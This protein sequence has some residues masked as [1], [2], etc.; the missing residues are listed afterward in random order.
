[1]PRQA[2][3][4]A[5]LV[6]ARRGYRELRGGP[7]VWLDTLGRRPSQGPAGGWSG[8]FELEAFPDAI[9]DLT[10]WVDRD[11]SPA[12]YA[13]SSQTR[14]CN[15]LEGDVRWQYRLDFH[16]LAEDLYVPHY[17]DH[18]AREEE[19]HDPRPRGVYLGLAEA[20]EQLERHLV[21]RIGPCSGPQ[22]GLR[23]RAPHEPAKG[24]VVIEPAHPAR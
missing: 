18:M 16:P 20:L 5:A 24:T 12:V 6:L 22:P 15:A 13:Y 2:R 9:F 19:D 11:K 3:H 7:L 8:Y 23:G 21:I 1:M 17:H 4:A 10:Q 14:Y